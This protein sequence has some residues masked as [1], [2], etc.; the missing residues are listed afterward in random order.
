M[1]RTT[2]AVLVDSRMQDAKRGRRIAGE[3]KQTALTKG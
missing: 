2:A 3:F 1:G